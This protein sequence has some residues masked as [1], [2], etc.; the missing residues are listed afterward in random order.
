ML[1]GQYLKEGRERLGLSQGKLAEKLG[2]KSSQFVSNIERGEA[3]VPP[4]RI[5]DVVSFLNL[6]LTKVIELH[7]ADYRK[8]YEKRIHYR[9]KH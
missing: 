8:D 5:R 7:T 2:W 6:S 4:E 9:R 1:L 3:Q